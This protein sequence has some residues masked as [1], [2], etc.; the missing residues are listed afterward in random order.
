MRGWKVAVLIVGLVAALVGGVIG[1]HALFKESNAWAPAVQAS[2]TIVLV[3]ITGAYAYLT[4][5]LVVAQRTGPRRATHETALGDLSQFLARHNEA[6]WTASRLFPVDT[7]AR[8]PMIPDVTASR[9]ALHDVRDGLLERVAVL[10][11]SLRGAALG[12]AAHV[13]QA[14]TELQ[15]LAA[16]LLEETEAGLAAKRSWT[17]RGAER[18]HKASND[19]ER[20][21]L[22]PDVL[23]G[24]WTKT[25]EERWEG[26]TGAVDRVLTS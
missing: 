18:A 17:W 14:E 21:E 2:S 24:R 20:A 11:E 10:P 4:H 7:E 15:T 13:L 25:A 3:A 22:W 16:A 5:G 1:L 6:V 23:R 8:P 9:D 19:P 26:L 12:T